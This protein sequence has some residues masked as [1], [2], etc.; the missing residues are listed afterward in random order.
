MAQISDEDFL[1]QDDD[2][3]PAP[4]HATRVSDYDFLQQPD[5]VGATEPVAKPDYASMSA[6]DV[7][8]RAWHN[9]P[10]D[11]WD[12]AKGVGNAVMHPVDTAKSLYHAGRGAASRAGLLQGSD[13]TRQRDEAAFDAMAAPY[14]ALK[15]G[16]WD[17]DW[18][19]MKEQ[20]AEHPVGTLASYAP[21]AGGAAGAAA[22]GL[23]VA[24]GAADAAGMMGTAN[25][26]DLAAKGASGAARVSKAATNATDPLWL[27]G[28]AAAGAT[29][30]V[31]RGAKSAAGI[32]AGIPPSTIGDAFNAGR[33]GGD[34]ADVYRV[35][36]KGEQG[37]LEISRASDTAFKKLQDR[38]RN[39]WAQSK[40]GV[41]AAAK[42]DVDLTPLQAA[43]NR[44]WDRLPPRSIA[45]DTGAHDT[46]DA[47]GE[48]LRARVA[49]SAMDRGIHGIDQLKQ[50]LWDRS[51]ATNDPATRNAILELHAGTRESLGKHAPDYAKLMD[52]YQELRD[53]LQDLNK[54][55]GLGDR[56]AATSQLN[57]IISSQKTEHGQ[58][59]LRQLAEE[60]PSIP[61]MI[62][63]AAAHK[64]MPADL[65]SHMMGAMLLGGAGFL[66]H[67]ALGAAGLAEPVLRSPHVVSGTAYRAGQMARG[68]D[69]VGST[70]GAAAPVLRPLGAALSR[71]DEAERPAHARGGRV[72]HQHLVDRLMRSVEHAKKAEQTRTSALLDHPDEHVA[73]ALKVAQAAI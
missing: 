15:K 34:A 39:E 33:L 65:L 11:A 70:Y 48:K 50:E 73:A 54:S 40:A 71:E 68:A 63:G 56:M 67:P 2:P 30:L 17:H 42:G 16:V 5:S 72:G 21:V 59:L 62:A 14:T 29:D 61:Y 49:G 27:A 58:K 55:L 51:R 57:K 22:K 52:Q 6:G 43:W 41:E 18:A 9:A 45:L 64:N 28:K 31:G 60:D 32:S 12:M 23:G 19:P 69:A 24:S 7:A 35:F 26:L 38:L 53:N 66:A 10:G 13:D 3:A 47:I 44:A 20:I 8:S 37:P 1:R 36:S 25:A 4:A 46:L